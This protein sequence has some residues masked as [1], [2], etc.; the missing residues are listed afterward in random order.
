VS[1]DQA[2]EQLIEDTLDSHVFC[3]SDIDGLQEEVDGS[4]EALLADFIRT[5]NPCGVGQL[6][7]DAV[8]KAIS[9]AFG[10]VFLED[11]QEI[12]HENEMARR[13]S[14]AIRRHE[15]EKAKSMAERP[16]V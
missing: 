16:S 3:A 15:A 12:V 1:V 11:G 2:V 5:K 9:K 4:I 8:A 14:D 13:I 6:F 10:I 7:Q